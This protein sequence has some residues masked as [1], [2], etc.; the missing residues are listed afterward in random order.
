M[1][2]P[3]IIQR[4]LELRAS[5]PLKERRPDRLFTKRL[6]EPR[7]IL[8]LVE[9]QEDGSELKLEARR[10]YVVALAT[11]FEVYWREF[12]RFS[13]DRYRPSEE[14][15]SHLTKISV[16]LADVGAILGRKL[17]FGELISCAYSFRGPEALNSTASAIL[18]FDAFSEFRERR[19]EIRVI[20]DRRHKKPLRKKWIR[21]GAEV[22]KAA[23]PQLSRCFSIRNEVV[24][25]MGTKFKLTQ[26]DMFEIEGQTSTF[27]VFFSLFLEGE[28]DICFGKKSR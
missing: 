10:Q 5:A 2:T 28:L 3:R 15:V 13:L 23:L 22:L 1:A 9:K 24:H 19:F 12:F 27:D 16:T 7:E 8:R 25:N 18:R 21:S 14:T 20:P 6:Q 4:A 26:Q 17:T 11:A